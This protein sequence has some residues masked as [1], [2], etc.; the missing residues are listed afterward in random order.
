MYW[1][2]LIYSALELDKYR[3][4]IFGDKEAARFIE[5]LEKK[6]EEAKK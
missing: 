5:I 6:R 3:V 4:P 2:T 1:L